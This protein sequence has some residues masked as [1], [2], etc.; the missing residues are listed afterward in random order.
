MN[1]KIGDSTFMKHLRPHFEKAPKLTV[2]RRN[3]VRAMAVS[4][5]YVWVWSECAK[6]FPKIIPHPGCRL[7]W[8][9]LKPGAGRTIESACDPLTYAKAEVASGRAKNIASDP[10]MSAD[11]IRPNRPRYY[12]FWKS[13]TK[14]SCVKAEKAGHDGKDALLITGSNSLF[15]LAQTY[16]VKGDQLYY[17]RARI[18]KVNNKSGQYCLMV[19]YVDNLKRAAMGRTTVTARFGE[20]DADGWQIAEMAVSVPENMAKMHV[21][22]CGNWMFENDQIIADMMEVYKIDDGHALPL[23]R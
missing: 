8:E 23:K 13:G 9:D 16:N 1:D 5:E 2:L 18:K 15:T 6:W 17:V 11:F 20:P 14:G 4:D 12:D 3:L 21:R 10:T 22:I 7:M 19:A